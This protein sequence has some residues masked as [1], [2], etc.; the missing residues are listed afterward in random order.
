[1]EEDNGVQ[2]RYVADVKSAS[3]SASVLRDFDRT[4]GEEALAGLG[5]G[6]GTP[7]FQE[8]ERLTSSYE[9]S[10]KEIPA[11]KRA[12]FTAKFMLQTFEVLKLRETPV[13][14]IGHEGEPLFQRCQSVEELTS[15]VSF[16]YQM[17]FGFST[18]IQE[19]TKALVAGLLPGDYYTNVSRDY[20]KV[21]DQWYWNIPEA[22]ICSEQRLP[23]HTRVFARMFDTDEGGEDENVFVVP[24]FDGTDCQLMLRTYNALKDIP[25]SEWPEEYH[26][27]CFKDWSIDRPEVEFGMFT[28]VALPFMKPGLLRGSI[29]NVGEGHNGKS[30]LL[31]LATSLI[32]ARNTTQVSGNDLGKWDYLVD[33]QTTWFN[34][35]SET[36]LEFLQEN[37]GA[38]KTIS[39]HETLAVRKKHGDASIPVRGNFPMAFNIN[40]VPKFGED[41]SAILSRMFLNN[42]DRDFEAEGRSVKNYAR[43]A[44]LADKSTMPTLTGMVLAFAHYYSQPEHLWAPSASMLSELAVLTD[45]ATPEKR[46]LEWF[47][48]FFRG[49]TGISLVKSDY[50]NFGYQEGNTYD[51]RNIAQGT[52]LFK[53]FKRRNGRESTRYVLTD[54]PED[55]S[56]KKLLILSKRLYIRKYMGAMDWEQFQ[57]S[58][59]S[60]VYRMMQDYLTREEQI[61]EDLRTRGDSRSEEQIRCK[62]VREMWADIEAE[63]GRYPYEQ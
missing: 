39:A 1:M 25:Y 9:L 22:T 4:R 27:Q 37:T 32:G 56:D 15:Y 5:H 44:F 58:G 52:L 26:F 55:T 57:N 10:G 3:A 28:V 7:L 11:K 42:F 2:V 29:F 17:F 40:K 21:C 47:K 18:D 50:A 13:F 51:L 53:P 41:A 61:K 31:G 8:Y 19:A 12:G 46:Y 45:T 60:I 33:L 14:Y 54:A 62:V 49:Y 24:E 34:C 43:K 20:I 30:V 16:W 35:P 23:S 63:Q 59:E 36:E 6:P 38:F 48:R